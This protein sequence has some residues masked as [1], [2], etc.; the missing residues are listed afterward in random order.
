MVNFTNIAQ[1]VFSILI[2]ISCSWALDTNLKVIKAISD[3]KECGVDF[4]NMDR[5]K[6]FSVMM[7]IIAVL[8]VLYNSYIFYKDM[9]QHQN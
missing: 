8:H 1:L 4:G 9:K 6:N 3:K 2:L 7:L 5:A